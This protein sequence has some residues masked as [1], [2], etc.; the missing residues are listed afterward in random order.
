VTFADGFAYER[1]ALQRAL[2]KAPGVSPMTG[3]KFENL[4]PDKNLV[5]KNPVLQSACRLWKEVATKT[6]RSITFE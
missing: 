1:T 2:R 3:E 4:D 5:E 6:K